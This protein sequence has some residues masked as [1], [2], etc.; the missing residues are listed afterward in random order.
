[1]YELSIIISDNHRLIPE[2]LNHLKIL[3]TNILLTQSLTHL[4]LVVYVIEL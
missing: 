4:I 1:M 2:L 3:L